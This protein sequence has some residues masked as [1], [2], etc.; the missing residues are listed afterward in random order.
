MI[1]FVKD[2]YALLL[3]IAT[4]GVGW[5]I[6]TRTEWW[7]SNTAKAEEAAKQEKLKHDMLKEQALASASIEANQVGMQT[8]V[9]ALA[10]SVARE[11]EAWALV[12]SIREDRDSTMREMGTLRESVATLSTAHN[13]CERRLLQFQQSLVI[14]EEKQE[15]ERRMFRLRYDDATEKNHRL[16]NENRRLGGNATATDLVG[17][18]DLSLPAKGKE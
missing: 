17:P 6:K 7:K 3:I 5:L 8:M 9:A 16:F 18:A 12:T 11:R 14:F 13:D 2:W 4:G 10:G 1:E 15:A